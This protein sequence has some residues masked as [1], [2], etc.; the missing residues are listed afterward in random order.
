MVVGGGGY[1]TVHQAEI[2]MKVAIR[3]TDFTANSSNK[4]QYY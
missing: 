2:F 1:Q 3:Y 4:Y